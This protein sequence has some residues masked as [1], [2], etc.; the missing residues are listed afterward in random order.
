MTQ[1]G[2][3]PAEVSGTN[4]GAGELMRKERGSQGQAPHLHQ[5]LQ[6]PSL[7]IEITGDISIHR[8]PEFSPLC[9]SAS[10]PTHTVD[11]SDT[12]TASREGRVI[13]SERAV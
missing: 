6:S 12:N 9:K 7:K 10:R 11:V 8:G 3:I 2:V 5:H 1:S 13:R 4:R